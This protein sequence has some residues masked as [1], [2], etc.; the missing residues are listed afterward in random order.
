V[1]L[2]EGDEAALAGRLAARGQAA[3]AIEGRPVEYHRAV[4]QAFRALAEQDPQGFVRIDAIGTPEQVHAR[5]LAAIGDL[6]E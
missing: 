2:L 4:A 3:D 5:I 6:M 1:I